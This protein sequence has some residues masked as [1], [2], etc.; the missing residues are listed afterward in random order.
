MLDATSSYVFE[1]QVLPENRSAELHSAVSP[2]CNRQLVEMFRRAQSAGVAQN[3][4]LR[5]GRLQIC[6]TSAAT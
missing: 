1:P 3:A 5:Y 4:I 2:I 6:A